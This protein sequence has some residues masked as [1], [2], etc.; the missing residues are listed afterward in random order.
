MKKTLF[1]V[2][3][4]LTSVSLWAKDQPNK[5][6]IKTSA[7]CEMCKERIEKNLAYTK[8]VEASDLNLDDKVVTVTYNPK[9]TSVEKIKKAITEVGYDAD[10]QT[11]N[12]KG[13][14]KLPECCKKDAAPHH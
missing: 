2:L 8:G 14:Q 6:K 3:A 13:Y 10:E 5:V 4:L 1:L 7:I 11:A 12:Q 9:K